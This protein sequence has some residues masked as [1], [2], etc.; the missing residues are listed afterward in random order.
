MVVWHF[1]AFSYK[2]FGIF[3]KIKPGNPVR[4]LG[5]HLGMD[6]MTCCDISPVKR[7]IR[8]RGSWMVNGQSKSSLVTVNLA[9]HRHA[10][11]I[12]WEIL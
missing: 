1:L 6:L 9:S 3:S 7:V 11:L 10:G 5:K 4:G 8:M 12:L 2:R